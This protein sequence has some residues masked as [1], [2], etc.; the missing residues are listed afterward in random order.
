MSSN[1]KN[2]SCHK[3]QAVSDFSPGRDI[4]RSETCGS[5]HAE[6]RCCKMCVFYDKSSYNECKEPMAERVLEKEKTNFCDHFKA[7]NAAPATS[8]KDDILA[9][10][11]ALFKK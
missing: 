10:A 2:L 7:G 9:Q 4:P 11:N 5:C 1:N 8:A 3:C 6:L